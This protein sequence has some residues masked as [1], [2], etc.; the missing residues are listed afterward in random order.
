MSNCL[1]PHG[2]QHTRALC[3]YL[4][5]IAQVHVHWIGDAIW[6]SQPLLPSSPFTLSF[7]ESGSFLVSWLFASSGQSIGASS[8]AS[9]LP[10]SIQG[11][12]PLGL[13]GLVCSTSFHSS[14]C[15]WTFRLLSCLGYCEWPCMN[16]GVHISLNY[17]L[18]QTHALECGCWVTWWF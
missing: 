2:L 6:P 12:F 7:P 15:W 5:E 18:L 16:L 17:S 13:A 1:W 11:L 10:M 4:P 3:H 14:L 9:V 8:S